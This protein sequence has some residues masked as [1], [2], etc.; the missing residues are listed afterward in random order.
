MPGIIG[1]LYLAKSLNDNPLFIN[2]IGRPDNTHADF[3]EI[4]LFLPDVISLNDLLFRIRKKGEW[5]A[6][7]LLKLLVGGHIVLTHPKDNR[8][9]F[10]ELGI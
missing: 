4:L 9:L 10:P 7:F 1:S 5:E 8:S 3:P 2:Q 6:V